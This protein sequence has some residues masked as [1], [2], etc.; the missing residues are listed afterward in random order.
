MLA[1]VGGELCKELHSLPLSSVLKWRIPENAPVHDLA[2]KKRVPSDCERSPRPS[3]KLVRAI[4][5]EYLMS[6]SSEYRLV[7]SKICTGYDPVES[8]GYS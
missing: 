8:V 6:R 2:N 5:S 7:V 1:K 3:N 4:E